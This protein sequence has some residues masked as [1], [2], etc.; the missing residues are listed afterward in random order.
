[1]AIG[2]PAGGIFKERNP[3]SVADYILGDV[4][5]LTTRFYPREN[6]PLSPELDAALLAHLDRVRE[7]YPELWREKGNYAE[8][9][10]S[11][12]AV[13]HP[14]ASIYVPAHELLNCEAFYADVPNL[15][16]LF[17]QHGLEG[18]RNYTRYPRQ[19]TWDPTRTAAD[20][21]DVPSFKLRVELIP[22]IKSNL[23]PGDS[24]N[25]RNSV[26]KAHKELQAWTYNETNRWG[27][28]L[29]QN[30]DYDNIQIVGE[31]NTI[32]FYWFERVGDLPVLRS[33]VYPKHGN[34]S[35][36]FSI[37]VPALSWMSIIPSFHKAETLSFYIADEWLGIAG[38]TPFS[39]TNIK[40]LDGD[41][42]EKAAELRKDERYTVLPE[43]DVNAK[44]KTWLNKAATKSVKPWEGHHVRSWGFT[45][46]LKDG[47]AVMA[48]DGYRIHL[49]YGDYPE[50]HFLR[51]T[52]SVAF[53]GNPPA[54]SLF[55]NTDN[56]ILHEFCLDSALMTKA[57]KRMKS[58][59]PDFVTVTWRG[60]EEGGLVFS[61][62][63]SH[64]GDIEAFVPATTSYWQDKHRWIKLTISLPFLL[65]ALSGFS[66]PIVFAVTNCTI[67]IQQDR[68]MAVI[69]KAE[70]DRK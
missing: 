4:Y 23:I 11:E 29:S 57:L 12:H 38:G 51:L 20:Y 17:Q 16:A 15:E 13:A 2:Y 45:Q 22:T 34:T 43:I 58:M 24:G 37:R 50:D 30:W 55:L 26:Y 62:N 69:V 70:D 32:T 48:T 14:L 35:G 25:R 47:V 5:A 33:A 41:L 31:G 61:P 52:K 68:R 39:W 6:P 44:L 9:P 27:N 66:G 59:D 18:L 56:H 19:R 42:R 21:P 3:A 65:D 8:R 49:E 54:V 60:F 46:R 10:I 7:T 67:R 28:P 53:K 64:Q 1:M 36:D 63:K 40:L